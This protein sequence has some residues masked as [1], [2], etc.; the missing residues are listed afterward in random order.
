MPRDIIC[1][2]V[3][4]AVGDGVRT[5]GILSDPEGFRR[6]TAVIVAH[7]AAND[8]E[9]PLIVFFARGLTGAGYPALRFNF[10]YRHRGLLAPD[11]QTVLEKTWRGAYDFIVGGTGMEIETVIAAGKS[12]GGRVAS[13]MVARG[14]LPAGGLVF[15][16]YPL[17]APGAPEKRRDAHFGLLETP[18][19]FFAG[20]RDP[21][22][23]LETLRGA[24]RRLKAPWDLR[25]V[26]GGDH[27][28]HLP[29]AEGREEPAVHERI[30][31]ETVSWLQGRFPSKT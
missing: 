23:D 20:S 13:Q 18:L 24:L 6:G 10:P 25:V 19:L 8:M 16:G 2:E 21:L 27:S 12:L 11:D 30:V 26:E 31:R 1:R 28:F 15:L 4:I 14:D 5:S 29:G 7:G 3:D 17:H 22:C 9:H